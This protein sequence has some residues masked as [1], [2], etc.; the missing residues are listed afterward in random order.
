[1]DIKKILLDEFKIKKKHLDNVI[2]LLDEGNTIP[3]IARY[4]KEMTGEMQDTVLRDLSNRLDYLRNLESRKE[5]VIRLIDEQEK[6]TEE[7]EEKI[8]K[9]KT[10]QR[11]EDLYRPYKKKRRTR[12]TKAKEKG[13]EPLADIILEQKLEG[14]KFEAKVLEFINEE[15]EVLTRE[16]AL[17]GAMDIIA[18]IVSEDPDDRVWIKNTIYNNASMDVEAVEKEEKS[19]YEMYYEYKEPVKKIPNHRILAINRGEKEKK[20]KVNLEINHEN[21][22]RKL[23]GKIITNP[24]WKEKAHLEYAIE[25]GYKRLLFP[26]IER[27]IR[28]DLTLRA[29]DDAIDVFSMNL[30]PL[31]MQPPIKDKVVMALDPGFRTGCKVA[32]VDEIGNPIDHTAIFPHPPQNKREESKKTLKSLIQKYRVNIIAI[33]NGTASRETENLVS[34]LISEIED[35]VYYII[36]SEAGASIYSASNVGIK[37]FPD[38]DVTVR[39]AISI[40]RRLQDALAELVK[41]DPKH[42]GVGQYQHDLNQKKLDEALSA[43][44]EDTVNSVGVDL[45]TASGPL[46]GYVSGISNRVANSIIK[47]REEN[48]RFKSRKELSKVKGLGPKTFEQSAGFLRISGGENLLDNTGVHPE[49][50]DIATRLIELDYHNIDLEELSNSLDIGIPTLRDIIKELDSPGRDPRD[51]EIKPI[52]RQDVLSVDDLKI[53]MVL[54][55]TVRNVIDFGAFVDIGVKEDGLVHISQISNK[56]V[57]HPKEVVSVGD[58]VDVKIIDIDKERGRIALSMKDL[59]KK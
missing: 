36:V 2:N 58:I 1:M 59:N 16:D 57:K 32:I 23:Q 18:E 39:G 45:N 11:V 4:R 54:K 48:G 56:F 3:F 44:V 20:L 27:E 30:E 24:E 51:E 47:Y 10:L 26:S 49:T 17:N 34:E 52:L 14:N 50:Y 25:D 12:A 19:V 7:L 53:N 28:S 6:L 13:L 15:K 9:A 5:E 29:E 22:I 35:E 43:V 31:L 8:K 46:L 41:I 38:L 40:A 21:I 37:E 55:G 42:I 33:G